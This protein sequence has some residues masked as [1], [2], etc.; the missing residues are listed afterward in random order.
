MSREIVRNFKSERTHVADVESEREAVAFGR[1]YR[2]PDKSTRA[3]CGVAIADGVIM[4]SSIVKCPTCRFA[5]DR[6]L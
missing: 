4:K 2:K 5:E 1:T 6:G 3:L